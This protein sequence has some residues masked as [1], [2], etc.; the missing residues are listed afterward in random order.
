MHD[1]SDLF[2]AEGPLATAIPGFAT[3][4]EQ[5]E[6][7]EQVAMALRAHGRL[8]VEAGTGTG[9]TFAYLVPALLSGRRV[10]VSTGTR[11]LQ[12]QLFHRDLPTVARAIG[13]PVRVAL[14]KG[15]A[16][17]LCIH[18]LEL[19][20]Q[21]AAAR[22]LRREVA[23]GLGKVREWARVTR[24][25]D[26][27]ELTQLSDSD[28][29][30][31]WVTSTRDNCLGPECPSFDRCH[32][33]QARRDAQAA[34]VVVVN[35]HL[36]MADLVLKEEGFGDL[37][38]GADAIVIDEAHQLPE[39]AANFL[40]FAVSS[41]QLQS[42]SR[43]VAAELLATGARHDVSATFAQT[44]DRHLFDLQDALRGPRE[45][46]EAREWSGH[47]VE[48]IEQLQGLLSEFVA[49]LG[50]A[51]K[52]S[53]A[54]AALRRRGAEL[55]ARLRMLVAQDEEAASVRWAQSTTHGVTLHYVPVDVAEQ[56]G[57]LVE[58]HTSAW[59]C[60]SATLAVGDSFDHFMG[61]LGMREAT[62]V[63]FG[64]PFSYERQTLLYLPRGL[65]PPSSP[66]HTE[67]V[68]DAALPV[69]HAA[70]GRAFLLFTSHR[71]LRDAAEIL[72]QRLGATLPFPV[73][74]QGDGP[75]ESLLSKF[76]EYG[77]AVLLGTSS[78]WEGVD[79]KGAAL[80]VVV[81]DKLPF[82]APDDPVLKARLDAIEQRGG[83]PFFEEQ[84]P[85]A[86]IALKQGV[87][88]LM[89]DPNDFGVVMLCDQR[90]RTR[91]YGRIFLESLPPM[92][93]TERIDE[94]EEFLYE[95]LASVGIA[96]QA[97]RRV[98]P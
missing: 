87:G 25:G 95:K 6:M 54:I 73:L 11:N 13:R 60:T 45:R 58:G 22:G 82:A 88:R 23:R 29:V 34:D 18:R 14:L 42:L 84:I 92:P 8:I 50:E 89:R 91:A 53:T 38:P 46:T 40:G 5:I 86:V 2:G 79:V 7:A 26:I 80:C 4:D 52:D 74:V 57:A 93:R 97:P 81:I 33:V 21:Q 62:T 96:A 51:A 66:R 27:A 30:W 39:I 71:A 17:Y 68:I 63:R 16:N 44:L 56:L 65:D 77:N 70:G 43:D 47:V 35:H 49:A 78:F 31:Q 24:Q 36:L 41:R 85:Q 3:R 67:Q 9:K 98:A 90:L 19:A 75:R 64:S 55:A 28:P 83:S 1:Y 12:D 94:V 10:I 15:R 59:I 48:S 20:E 76:R 37:L 69:L 61:R 72:L 32:V